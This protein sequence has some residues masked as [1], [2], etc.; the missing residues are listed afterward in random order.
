MIMMMMMISETH[1]L[2]LMRLCVNVA[3]VLHSAVI[4]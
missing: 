4:G 3:P 1:G 2:R